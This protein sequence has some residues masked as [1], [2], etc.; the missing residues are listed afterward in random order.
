MAKTVTR[1]YISKKT[2]KVVTKVYTY[3]TTSTDYYNRKVKT[4]KPARILT[5]TGKIIKKNYKKYVETL[6][7]S[8][9]LEANAIIRNAIKE[10]KNLTATRMQYQIQKM[11]ILSVIDSAGMTAEQVAFQVNA[12]VD[13]LLNIA[14]WNTTTKA[15]GGVHIGSVFTNP[16][17]GK[18]YKFDV[19]YDGTSVMLDANV[20]N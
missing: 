3:G 12:T 19:N 20:V 11:Q 13:E 9:R 4:K 14:N 1:T 18:Q 16:N 10:G 7:G 8:D 6:S 5:S 15:D 2:G 17:T